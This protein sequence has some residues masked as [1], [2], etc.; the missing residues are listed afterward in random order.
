MAEVNTTL[1]INYTLVKQEISFLY[2]SHT[3]VY[4]IGFTNLV[5]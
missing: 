5:L 3:L 4:I 2:H 1:Q